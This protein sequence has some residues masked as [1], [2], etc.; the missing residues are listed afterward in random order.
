MKRNVNLYLNKQFVKR[1][2]N[3]TT[4]KIQNSEQETSPATISKNKNKNKIK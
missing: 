2:V 1:N 4:G 3:S